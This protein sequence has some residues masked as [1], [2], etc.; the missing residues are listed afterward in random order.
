M[1]DKNTIYKDICEHLNLS[2]DDITKYNTFFTSENGAIDKSLE[3]INRICLQN[4]DAQDITSQFKGNGLFN[5]MFNRFPINSVSH[6]YELQT[7]KSWLEL[8]DWE[9]YELNDIYQL[10]RTNVFQDGL[11]YKIIYNSGYINAGDNLTL[12]QVMPA[13]LLHILIEM[14][15]WEFKESNL[16]PDIKGGLLGIKNRSESF[17]GISGT[18]SYKD[19]DRDWERQLLRFTAPIIFEV[20]N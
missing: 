7:D 1:I 8:T 11:R 17:Q 3:K 6:L 14:C 10:E 9:F 16:N 15:F 13:D 5:M 19:M 4:I 2:S 12:G 20:I 18:T